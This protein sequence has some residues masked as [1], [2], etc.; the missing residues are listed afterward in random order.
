M[1]I[2][3]KVEAVLS[4]IRPFL[5]KD[6]GDIKLVSIKDGVAK[7]QFLGFCSTCNKSTMTLNSISAIITEKVVE[8][9]EVIE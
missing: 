6:G 9:K 7:V 4:E 3:S 5:Q 8:I 1:S 2:F